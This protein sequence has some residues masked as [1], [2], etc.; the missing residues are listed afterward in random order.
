M[1]PTTTNTWSTR[2]FFFDFLLSCLFAV[3]LFCFFFCPALTSLFCTDISHSASFYKFPSSSSVSFL[4][5]IIIIKNFW[6]KIDCIY[7]TL[8]T[9][10]IVWGNLTCFI[11]IGFYT[12]KLLIHPIK[13][14]QKL[15]TRTWVIDSKF[16]RPIIVNFSNNSHPLDT[17]ILK[18]NLNLHCIKNL[19]A[20]N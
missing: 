12:A 2:T 20:T 19:S 9:I 10:F 13:V 8:L 3:F 7:Q 16:Q 14:K 4:F 17:N 11:N 15:L 5:L 6:R 1:K 18:S